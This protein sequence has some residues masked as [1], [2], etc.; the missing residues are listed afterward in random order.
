MLVKARIKLDSSSSITGILYS[1]KQLQVVPLLFLNFYV[2]V[3]A[4]MGNQIVLDVALYTQ[5]TPL[6]F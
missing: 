4:R 3:F 1:L 6:E 5:V 2:C